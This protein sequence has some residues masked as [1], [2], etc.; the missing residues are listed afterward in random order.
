MHARRAPSLALLLG[1]AVAC[2]GADPKADPTPEGADGADGASDG[3]GGAD[4]ADGGTDGGADGG[5][6]TA[7][8]G[9]PTPSEDPA[10]ALLASLDA[11]SAEPVRVTDER[12]RLTWID[13][14][15]PLSA[16]ADPFAA[17]RGALAPWASLWHLGRPDRDLVPDAHSV[18]EA[19][20]MSATWFS[21]R[22]GDIPVYGARVGVF[23]QEGRVK[24][25]IGSVPRAPI[26]PRTPTLSASLVSRGLVSEGWTVLSDPSLAFYDPSLFGGPESGVTLTYMV[27]VWSA[28]EGSG[29]T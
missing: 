13:V 6:D 1:L 20:G 17:A 25:L 23:A 10:E 24:H 29:L 16:D 28:E 18:E 9:A 2:R 14:D 27:R 3:D 15:L 21:V 5:A 7:D 11:A 4:G 22:A 26:A 8:T 19:S 12:G